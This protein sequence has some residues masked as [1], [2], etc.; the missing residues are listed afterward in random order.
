MF[1]PTYLS[2]FGNK[3]QFNQITFELF[4]NYPLCV[5]L[6]NEYIDARIPSIAFCPFI[7]GDPLETHTV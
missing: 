6:I 1:Y 4:C 3:T 7:Y 2:V 5:S